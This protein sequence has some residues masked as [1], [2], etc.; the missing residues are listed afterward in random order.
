M[1]V[2]NEDIYMASVRAF[3]LLGGF[4]S[5]EGIGANCREHASADRY[6]DVR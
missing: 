5:E 4:F 1:F 3:G 2:N 6:H